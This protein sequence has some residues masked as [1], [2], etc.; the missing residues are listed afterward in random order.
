MNVPYEI[1]KNVCNGIGPSWFPEILR[2]AISKLN[3]DLVVV[4]NNHD[5]GYYYGTGT[6]GDFLRQN[7]AFR[8]NGEKV[9][10]D[11]WAKQKVKYGWYDL[12]RLVL[13]WECHRIKRQAAI[14]AK[15]CNE[16]GWKAYTTAR[17]ERKEAEQQA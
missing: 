6:Q 11:K 5:L 2:D 12:R 16:K 17:K 15:L 14:F 7:E 8:I 4:A 10:D 1:A 13:L 3:P 9:A